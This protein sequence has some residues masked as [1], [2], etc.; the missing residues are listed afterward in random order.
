VNEAISGKALC[1][2]LRQDL[3]L[4]ETYA[5]LRM[6]FISQFRDAG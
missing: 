3:P 6:L 1:N 2:E 5:N 4:H